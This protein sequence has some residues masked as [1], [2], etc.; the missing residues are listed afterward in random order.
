MYLHPAPSLKP[1]HVLVNHVDFEHIRSRARRRLDV[2]GGEDALAWIDRAGESRAMTLR[3][4]H[5]PVEVKPAIG[6]TNRR[7]GVQLARPA[8]VAFVA[9][10][11]VH[12]PLLAGRQRR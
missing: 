10:T 4:E 9:H 2:H 6:E 1:A 3:Y 7:L 12:V 11:E 8:L 5:I